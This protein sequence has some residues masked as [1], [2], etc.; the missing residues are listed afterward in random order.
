[1]S[2]SLTMEY[3]DG[4]AA[5][6]RLIREGM[7]WSGREPNT[8]YL[9]LGDGTF[10]DVS[11]TSGIAF[12]DDARCF[13]MVDWDQDGD[14]DF[15]IA[16]RTAP[17][18]RFVRNDADGSNRWVAFHLAGAK[19]NRDAIGARVDVRAAGKRYVRILQAGSGYISQS[20]KWLNFGVGRNEKLDEVLVSW[21]D[22]STSRFEGVET[23][24]RYALVQGQK[25]LSVV[26]PAADPS[27]IVLAPST[28]K[29]IDPTEIARIG[30]SARVAVPPLS[31]KDDSGKTQS[32]SAGQGPLLVNFWSSTCASCMNELA[33]WSRAEETLRAAGL[34]ILA[35]SVDDANPDAKKSSAR[36]A[37]AR[38]HP[39]FPSG[40]A[41]DAWL[42]TFEILQRTLIDRQRRMPVPTS[43]LIDAK[44]RLAYIY[45]GPVDVDRLVTDVRNLKLEGLDFASAN[46]PFEGR[47]HQGPGSPRL[48]ETAR[49]FHD[50]GE[51]DPAMFYLEEARR[52]VGPPGT[53]GPAQRQLSDA[54]LRSGAAFLE[55]ER[56]EDA[57][58]ALRQAIAYNE[59]DSVPWY[60]LGQTMYF[61][62]RLDEAKKCYERSLKLDPSCAPAWNM[63]GAVLF[64][65]DDQNGAL[66]AY[67]H[68]VESDPNLTEAWFTLGVYYVNAENF[69][70][71]AKSF[72]RVVML[73]PEM[74]L[75]WTGLGN[76]LFMSG[77]KK[78][79][80][81][82]LQKAL[83][84]DPAN[85]RAK[86]LL[87]QAGGAAEPPK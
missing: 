79:A 70:E 25:D 58:K 46:A 37:I 75:G 14:L 21:P 44:G 40:P 6:N 49:M 80:I 53:D 87:A 77:D 51:P 86:G 73:R 18:L 16:N 15:W 23:N 60:A 28:P 8:M 24:Q 48:F 55:Q 54:Q 61:T 56:Y 12:P 22:G 31:V 68:A 7:S 78:A 11:F 66:A 32:L 26:K 10:S 81:P 83:Q 2:E 64:A 36:Q 5:V 1:M 27:K 42:G 52:I 82:A 33:G 35:L 50:R 17:K 74:S 41:T 47:W 19:V 69:R 63:L 34:S 29:P 9:N 3:A 76:C 57:E 59:N 39:W 4:W 20:S 30:L 84:L 45:K 72:Q 13:A 43:F 67:K 38:F 65:Q 85:E 71:G 62:K